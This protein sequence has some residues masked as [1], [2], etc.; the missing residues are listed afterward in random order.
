MTNAFD[1]FVRAAMVTIESHDP[2]LVGQTFPF[3]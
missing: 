1:A 2:S 3:R